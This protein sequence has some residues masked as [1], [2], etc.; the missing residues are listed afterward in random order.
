MRVPSEL[1]AGSQRFDVRGW[2]GP[3][4]G[5]LR[6][7][8]YVADRAKLSWQKSSSSGAT[9]SDG[10]R[11]VTES[12]RSGHFQ[13]HAP[14]A[15][16]IG[17]SCSVERRTTL[18]QAQRLKLIGMRWE[19][20]VETA[21]QI[22]TFRCQF[23]RAAA[24]PFELLVELGREGHASV[25]GVAITIDM[26]SENSHQP[27][28]TVETRVGFLL[29]EAG[30]QVAAVDL[31]HAWSVTLRNDLASPRRDEIAAIAAS[32]LMLR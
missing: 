20:K 22:E 30:R 2:L 32:L 14:N 17:A 19:D 9:L 7:G 29:A 27:F 13:F 23:E 8:P 16:R 18:M 24:S 21:E 1:A 3:W 4:S 11:E 28:P 12:R 15:G 25:D 5:K 6:F 31:N 26:V 10:R